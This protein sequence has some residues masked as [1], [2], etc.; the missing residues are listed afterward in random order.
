MQ[1][2]KFFE[3]IFG[4]CLQE[5][6]D[7]RRQGVWRELAGGRGGRNGVPWQSWGAAAVGPETRLLVHSL[8]HC[9]ALPSNEAWLPLG[10]HCSLS[11]LHP[12][13]P[14]GCYCGQYWDHGGEIL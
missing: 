3:K 1:Y 13:A 14:I 4:D 8:E 7:D 11:S 2:N 5:K 10:H 12:C 9:S 6:N